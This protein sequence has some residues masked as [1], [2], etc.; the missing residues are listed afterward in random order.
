M[1]SGDS[2]TCE[3]EEVL[4]KPLHGGEFLDTRTMHI[5]ALRPDYCS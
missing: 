4:C 1:H 2:S 3:S 5:L